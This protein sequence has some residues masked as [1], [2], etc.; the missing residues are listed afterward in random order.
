VKCFEF[1]EKTGSAG[2]IWPEEAE[3]DD[4]FAAA[5]LM[6]L[7]LRTVCRMWKRFKID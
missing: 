3:G 2:S 6:G 7:S 4:G 5:E 1:S